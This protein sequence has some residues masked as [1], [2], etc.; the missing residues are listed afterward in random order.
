MSN[1]SSYT[2]GYNSSFRCPV[3]ITL[4]YGNE[5]THF[6]I[7]DKQAHDLS[8]MLKEVNPPPHVSF[9]FT[10]EQNIK[11]AVY[12]E[13]NDTIV[14]KWRPIAFTFWRGKTTLNRTLALALSDSIK[15]FFR[16]SVPSE[17]KS[18]LNEDPMAGAQERTN[19]NL[20]GVFR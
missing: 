12:W 17:P 6:E 5:T 2:I 15:G 7:T 16:K 20:R 10:T 3:C 13:D 18:S 14:I 4:L 19:D 11:Y 8:Q 1:T 9:Y